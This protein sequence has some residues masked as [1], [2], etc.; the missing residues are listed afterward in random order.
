M[1]QNLWC[2]SCCLLGT[3]SIGV[4]TCERTRK[5]ILFISLENFTF[6]N[7]KSR[8]IVNIANVKHPSW[9]DQLV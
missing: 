9:D 3:L 7:K 8:V 5:L 6:K 4:Y 1:Q 2:V